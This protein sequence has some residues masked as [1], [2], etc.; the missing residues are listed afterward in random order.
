MAD[1]LDIARRV[2]PGAWKHLGG[3]TYV[4]DAFAPTCGFSVTFYR[5]GGDWLAFDSYED[6]ARGEDLATVLA[7]A[8][9]KVVA[10]VTTVVR[11]I[12]P[13]LVIRAIGHSGV[14]DE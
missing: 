13:D 5:I 10:S 3:S 9:D 12:G 4:L 7:E 11:A 1:P 6:L 14:A 8:R 2:W